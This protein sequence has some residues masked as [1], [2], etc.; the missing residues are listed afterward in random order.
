M[1][2]I[3]NV[4]D[5]EIFAIGLD[6]SEGIALAPDGFLYA[7][8]EAGQVY[9]IGVNG[10]V[11]EVANTGGFILGVAADA[12]SRL[13]L[14]DQV[15]RTVWSLDTR[16]GR[17]EAFTR[18]TSERK[19]Y[20]PNWGAFDNFG[21]YYLTDSGEWRKSNGCI[22]VVRPPGVS[23]LWCEDSID[24]PNGCAVS[25]DGKWLYVVESVPPRIV[26]IEIQ[27]DGSAGSRSV[28]VEMPGTVPDGVAIESD[29]SLI[30]ACYR[31]DTVYRWN[32]KTGLSVLASDPE[33]TVLSAPT[34]VVFFGE[35]LDR[36]V[37]PNL[38]RWHLTSGSGVQG[39]SLFYP[40]KALLGR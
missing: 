39:T 27:S 7:G 4:S 28:V 20:L 13:Y 14:C 29:G 9:R 18:G 21:N 36:W 15:H 34:N 6:H 10:S 32:P 22:F 11:D 24:F 16:S 35:R 3:L 40:S 23:E 37:V 2:S 26:K 19:L 17:K 1:D 30:I 5:L 8:G 38:G 12:E 33:G 31:P 25:P